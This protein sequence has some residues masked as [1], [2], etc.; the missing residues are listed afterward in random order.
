M[1]CLHFDLLRLLVA[2][3]PVA[4]IEVRHRLRLQIKS[5]EKSFSVEK[6]YTPTLAAV[7]QTVRSVE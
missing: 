4:R 7:V 2:H 1:R 6:S 3:Q 5:V